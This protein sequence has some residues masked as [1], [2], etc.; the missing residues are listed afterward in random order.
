MVLGFEE[1]ELVVGIALGDAWKRGRRVTIRPRLLGLLIASLRA[2][3][4]YD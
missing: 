2:L 1:T 4:L 3:T